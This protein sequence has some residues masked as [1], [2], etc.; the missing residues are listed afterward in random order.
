MKAI[1]KL[2]RFDKDLKL[3]EEVVKPSRSFTQG[4]IQLLYIL[5]AQIQAASP[6]PATDINGVSRNLQIQQWT[7]TGNAHSSLG[8]L[9]MGCG[10]G[11]TCENCWAM[12]SGGSFGTGQ[13]V[14]MYIESQELGIVIGTGTNAVSPLNTSLQTR[15]T[16]G[17]SVGQI[18]YGGCELV[19][20]TIINPDASL[21]IRRYFTNNSGNSIVVNEC[22]LY[23]AG[24]INGGSFS[25]CIARDLTGGVTINDTEIFRVTYTL[26]ITV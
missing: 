23:A 20:L 10:G 26:Q 4:L 8:C 1:L 3:I 25:F 6:Y 24:T 12:G 16:H 15:I 5:H 14:S 17:R 18:E 11:Q 21:D 7:A 19:N 9:K 13:N 2:Q 22:G